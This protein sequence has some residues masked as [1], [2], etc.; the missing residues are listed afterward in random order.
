M[1]R[2]H[3]LHYT[4]ESPGQKPPVEGCPDR[5]TSGQEGHANM[6]SNFPPL[7]MTWEVQW[8]AVALRLMAWR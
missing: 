8:G 4:S 6:D 5:Q 1:G 3:F 7:L 2:L